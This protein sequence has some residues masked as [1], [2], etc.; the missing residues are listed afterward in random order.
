MREKMS[1]GR[2]KYFREHPEARRAITERQRGKTT[3]LKQKE[4]VRKTGLMHK[5]EKNPNWKGGTSPMRKLLEGSNEYKRWR[6]QIFKRDNWTC[7]N[8]GNRGGKL[9]AH[10]MKSFAEFPELRLD[11]NNGLTVCEKCH[12]EIH[13]HQ[14]W[15]S[16]EAIQKVVKST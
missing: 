9:H 11:L 10:H 14:S 1:E 6:E 4:A 3:S 7:Q 5:K 16:K 8:C 12:Y 13:S 15:F 2:K